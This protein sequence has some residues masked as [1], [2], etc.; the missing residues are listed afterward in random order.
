MEVDAEVTLEDAEEALLLGESPL[1]RELS[2]SL[3]GCRDGVYSPEFYSPAEERPST[4]LP[5][6]EDKQH[7]DHPYT[8]PSLSCDPVQSS[9][10][11]QEVCFQSCYMLMSNLAPVLEGATFHV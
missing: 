6:S 11:A 9:S 2:L 5:P 1:Q 7:S 3:L 4:P 10:P 8:L